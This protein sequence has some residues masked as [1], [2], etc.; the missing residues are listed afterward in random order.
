VPNELYNQLYTNR[1]N[2]Q[3]TQPVQE[4]DNANF[5]DMVQNFREY[6]KNY[7]GD[8]RAEFMQKVQSGEISPWYFQELQKMGMMF[9]RFMP[10]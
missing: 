4:S 1:H 8:A 5:M 3:N 10:R 7:K 6:R 2:V 9:T